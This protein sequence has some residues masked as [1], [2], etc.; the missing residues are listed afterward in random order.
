MPTVSTTEMT[1]SESDISNAIA[2]LKSGNR[3]LFQNKLNR[4]AVWKKLDA[5]T[6]RGCYRSSI[7]NQLIDPRYT[8]EGRN[9]EDKG[10][11]NDYRH[12][13]PALYEIGSDRRW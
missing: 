6:K 8:F 3:L 1:L 12:H 5:A 11:G 4:D 13:M 9:I 7:R 10:F 2:Q